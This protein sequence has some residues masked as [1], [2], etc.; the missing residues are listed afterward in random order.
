MFDTL[1]TFLGGNNAGKNAIKEI[2]LAGTI[3]V[4]VRIFGFIKEATIAYYFG[5]SEYVD[6]YV[7]KFF[8]TYNKYSS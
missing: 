5:T 6:F 4:I 2:L 3:S 1:I 8:T 7:R